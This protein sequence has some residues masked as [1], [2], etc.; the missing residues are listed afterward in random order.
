ME[1]KHKLKQLYC[2]FIRATL[3]FLP[4]VPIIMRFRGGLYSLVLKSCGE[5]FQVAHNVHLVCVDGM[6]VGSNVYFAYSSVFIANKDVYIGDNVM[7]G[8]MCLLVC[9]NHTMK[10][11][12][13]RYG[14]CIYKP[15]HIGDNSWVGGHCV[16]LAGANLPNGSILAA[17]STLGKNFDSN[18]PAIFGGSPAKLIK[19]L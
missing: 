6:E 13:Y 15:I 3:F 19:V 8:P 9:D 14:E 1:L 10:E 17:N 16:I 18:V 11:G 5:N 12:S 4:D 2:W 7:F